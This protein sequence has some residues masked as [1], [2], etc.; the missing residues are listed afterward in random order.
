M[1]ENSYEVIHKC[2]SRTKRTWQR[3]QWYYKGVIAMVTLTPLREEDNTRRSRWDGRKCLLSLGEA[4]S[5]LAEV[6]YGVVLAEEDITDDP[7]LQAIRH[8]KG[9]KRGH[10]R[11]LNFQN[12]IGTL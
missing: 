9:S 5:I 7:Q 11:S 2:S 1:R 6:V 8:V 10:A 4:N 12:V 3:G